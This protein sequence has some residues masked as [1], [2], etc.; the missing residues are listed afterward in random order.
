MLVRCLPPATCTRRG[1]VA[2]TATGMVSVD[3]RQDGAVTLTPWRLDGC[4][5][6]LSL[7]SGCPLRWQASSGAPF[8]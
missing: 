6:W 3:A 4:G 8:G 5:C 2:L 7:L 1:A